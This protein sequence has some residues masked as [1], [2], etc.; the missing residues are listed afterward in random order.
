MIYNYRV[1]RNG[2]YYEAGQEVPDIL[3][4]IAVDEAENNADYL[5]RDE[6]AELETTTVR[7]GR[8]RNQSK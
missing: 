4:S 7:R 6:E 3:E 8:P 5:S 1:K 2:I